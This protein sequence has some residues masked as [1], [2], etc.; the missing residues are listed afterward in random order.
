MANDQDRHHAACVSLFDSASRPLLL[1]APILTEVCYL[2]E[3]ERGT[4]VEAGF[5]RSVRDG[6]F[7]LVALTDSDLDRMV[8]LVETYDD[9][10]LAVLSPLA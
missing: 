8:E 2:L 4:R 1:P 5:L 6:E 7:T 10:P 9:L 3:R